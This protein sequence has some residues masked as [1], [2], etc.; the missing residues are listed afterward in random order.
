MQV[1]SV[2][3]YVRTS[4]TKSQPVINQIR[5]LPV[6]RARDLLRF[7]NR[8]AAALVL[9]TLESAIANAE[10]NNNANIDELY[11]KAA[12][13]GVGP[14]IK[15]WRARARGRVNR[16]R[17]RTSHLTIVVSDEK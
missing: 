5:G 17:K 12:Y 15:R 1:R 16:I 13:V 8:K 7:N 9:K 3:R 6:E 14:Q 4:S 11:V 2:S 10:V